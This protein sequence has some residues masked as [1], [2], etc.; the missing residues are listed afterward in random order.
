MRIEVPDCEIQGIEGVGRV[1]KSDDEAWDTDMLIR[2]V[3]ILIQ[4]WI[5]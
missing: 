3:M 2:K 4:R 1:S 5:L